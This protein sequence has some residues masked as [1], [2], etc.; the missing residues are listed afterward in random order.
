M[1]D[2]PPPI[3]DQPVLQLQDVAQRYGGTK[4]LHGVTLQV[5]RG[6]IAV[7]LGTQGAGKTTLLQ[8][9]SGMLP[10]QG[11]SVAFKGEPIDGSDPSQ[12][13]AHGLSHVA[14]GRAVFAHLSA[15]DNLRMGAY[16][17]TD[18]DGVAQDMDAM[19]RYFPVLR[20][21]ADRPAGGL[22]AYLQLLLALACALMAKPDLLLLDAPAS[23][24]TP[25][26]SAELFER[27]IQINRER[28]IAMLITEGD[29]TSQALAIA[30][31]GYVLDKGRIVQE[32]TAATLREKIRFAA[33]G[34]PSR[35]LQET[36]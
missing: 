33:T 2:I 34:T 6:E 21:C 24:L 22:S 1:S 7:V 35:R 11:G 18:D 15:Q 26:Q 23:V 13:V 12:I 27:L 31:Y 4:V 19:V 10:P 30:D 28:G 16:T 14:Q 17:R 3:S 32:G 20:N 36:M 9:I 25:V 5:R 8:T 29:H